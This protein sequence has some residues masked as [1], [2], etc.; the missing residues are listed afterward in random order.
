[1][2]SDREYAIAAMDALASM[3][4]VEESLR[5][6]LIRVYAL[7]RKRLND[8][9]G[10]SLDY[11]D[12]EKDSLGTLIGKFQTHSNSEG[13][14]QT[15]M[16]LPRERNF[17][18]HESFLLREEQYKNS[19]HLDALHERAKKAKARADK[20]FREVLVEVARLDSLLK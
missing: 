20:C 19:S 6:Y 14:I 9:V 18:A 15:L 11:P 7:V 3:Q 10:F 8:D 12:V 16:S 13:L 4:F 2:E 5:M 17:L 1:M